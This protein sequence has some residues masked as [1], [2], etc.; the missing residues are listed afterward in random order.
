[1]KF[2]KKLLE[3]RRVIAA[4]VTLVAGALGLTLSPELQNA[5]ILIVSATV[6]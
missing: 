1:M 3:S 5:L 2:I 6:E 4:I